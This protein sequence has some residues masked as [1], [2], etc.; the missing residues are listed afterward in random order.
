MTTKL[1][2]ESLVMFREFD[3][4]LALTNWCS[5]VSPDTIE[6]ADLWQHNVLAKASHHWQSQCQR[7]LHHFY[8]SSRRVQVIIYCLA[9]MHLVQTNHAKSLHLKIWE[10]AVFL[11]KYSIVDSAIPRS[12]GK[13]A[14]LV[15]WPM[16]SMVEQHQQCLAARITQECLD[17]QK[18]NIQDYS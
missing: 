9:E 11:S 3:W 6:T 10:R 13:T 15:M 1:L 18:E 17:R 2:H 8:M 14:L 4:D 16:S 12:V 7:L 5:S